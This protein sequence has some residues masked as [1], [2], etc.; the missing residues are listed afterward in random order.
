MAAGR[1]SQILLFSTSSPRF[2]IYCLQCT[3]FAC[4]PRNPHRTEVAVILSPPLSHFM[5]SGLAETTCF[6]FFPFELCDLYKRGQ[7]KSGRHMHDEIPTEGRNGQRR[8]THLYGHQQ[9]LPI[10][11]TFLLIDQLNGL[12]LHFKSLNIYSSPWYFTDIHV[13]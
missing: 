4:F 3:S 10:L 7:E 2:I 11:I 1:G 6:H 5:D 9:F 12:P 13:K 8:T